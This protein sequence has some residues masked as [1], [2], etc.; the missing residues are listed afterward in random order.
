MVSVRIGTCSHLDE[1]EDP[2][3]VPMPHYHHGVTLK[4]Q[5]LYQEGLAGFAAGHQHQD[6]RGSCL[7]T[8]PTGHLDS[9]NQSSLQ[10]HSPALTAS[11]GAWDP[12]GASWSPG[13]QRPRG[14]RPAGRRGAPLTTQVPASPCQGPPPPPQP[15]WLGFQ[16]VSKLMD[17]HGAG[18]HQPGDGGT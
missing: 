5:L 2:V 6:P 1:G 8:R 9:S 14:L 7:P 3:C 18:T 17:W 13:W 10:G 11:S 16:A 4:I 15:G 12:C